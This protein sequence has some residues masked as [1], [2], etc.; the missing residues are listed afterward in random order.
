MAVLMP[1]I[2]AR[3][4]AVLRRDIVLKNDHDVVD[5]AP[6]LTLGGS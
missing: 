4:V 5:I 1:L 3:D 6:A 2:I